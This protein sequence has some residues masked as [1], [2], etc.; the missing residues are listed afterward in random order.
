MPKDVWGSLSDSDNYK[1]IVLCSAKCKIADYEI[2]Y[3]NMVSYI[4]LPCS[5]R[6]N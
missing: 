5:L 6:T 4:L 1:G 2:T 3:I